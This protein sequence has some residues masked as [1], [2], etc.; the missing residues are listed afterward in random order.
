MS[1]QQPRSC[2]G[3]LIPIILISCGHIAYQ[4]NNY[5]T[6]FL[7]ENST[8]AD[9]TIHQLSLD[10]KIGQLFILT[11][12]IPHSFSK[13]QSIISKNHLGGI[14]LHDI[15][16]RNYIA[17]IQKIRTSANLP[18]LELTDAHTS[19]NNQLSD[20]VDYPSN[21]TLSA[22][23]WDYVSQSIERKYIND[24][25]AMGINCSLS[26][27]IQTFKYNED[28]DEGKYR[29]SNNLE[30]I[31]YAASKVVMLQERK[32]LAIASAMN[33]YVDS[34]ADSTLIRSGFLKEFKPLVRSG[35]SGIL[36]DNRL[37]EGD[38]I[39]NRLPEFYKFFLK[40]HLQFEGLL[41]GKIDEQVSIKELLYAG[42]DL[43][44]IP[45]EQLDDAKG[46][47]EAL[48]AEGIISEATIN[49]KVHK[50]LLAKKWLGL[51]KKRPTRYV[52]YASQSKEK[53]DELFV[54]HLFEQS[55][56]LAHNPDSLL[57]FKDTYAKQFKV[58]NIG[59]RSLRTFNN[60]FFKYANFSSHLYR[61]QEDGKVNGLAFNPIKN[62][63]F[64]LT[65][66][67]INLSPV[68]HAQFIQSVNILSKDSKVVV[69]NFGNP[70]NFN[71]FDS[72][73]VAIQVFEKNQITEELVPQLLFG[74]IST[75]GKLPIEVSS[76]MPKG[77][78]NQIP[79]NRLKFTIPEEVGIPS[80]KLTKIDDIF[81]EAILRKA[82]PG[83]QVLVA[84]SGK[85]IYAKTFGHHTYEQKQM[86]EYT[87]LYDVASITKVAATTLAAM[88]LY[89]NG[90]I[91]VNTTLRNEIPLSSDATIKNIKIKDLFIHKSGLQRNMPIATYLKNRLMGDA[92][93][94]F[95]CKQQDETYTTEI[96]KDLYMN[97]TYQDSIMKE[98]NLLPRK[99]RHRRYLY[100]DVNFFLI[101]QLI[102]EK[103]R[104][105]LDDYLKWK[106]YQPLG[107][108]YCTFKPLERFPADLI[109]PTQD[110]Q[111][112]RK[113][114]VRGYVHDE[115]AALLGG[116]GGNAGLFA[117]AADLAALF[118]M[119]LNGGNYGG[120][121][122]LNKKTIDYFTSSK[123][124]N[125]RGL[126]FDKA[127]YNY[128]ASRSASIET[129]G[130]SGFSGT[131]VWVDPEEELIY[132]FL[133]NRIHPDARNPRLK[134]MRIRQRIHQV[135]YD[136][137]QSIDQP[138]ATLSWA[139]Q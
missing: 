57:P 36:I 10:E 33:V 102:E 119:L 127:R 39:T 43:F 121:K 134:K 79:T 107:L 114:L 49:E 63:A 6:P 78:N 85:V 99:Y 19:F 42:T 56:I 90:A 1:N 50:I 3:F 122:F 104:M 100:S 69:V 72:T 8:W 93:N 130:H 68:Q 11:S 27:D 24:L 112:W 41:F 60:T 46:Q 77:A 38:T 9:T 48:I 66:D 62:G 118:Q 2:L 117:N 15:S 7:Q 23:D 26:P 115:S 126:G 96:A 89:E 110:D 94:A 103:T 123:H 44:L 64:I 80:E 109:V 55:I 128:T 113:G 76:W 92:C 91:D 131:C 88:T 12:D 87:D 51:E 25:D 58:V 45:E 13:T 31:E 135:I 29:I 21:A 70:N 4:Q 65:L 35:L 67:N 132:I 17:T 74:G 40:R 95:F 98:V 138:T 136:A 14:L 124:G 84:K 83:G 71:Q 53:E 73:I 54:R 137:I 28:Y 108:R 106:Y 30:E 37:F 18:L 125:H 32:I 86:V 82:T 101:H 47:L 20:M 52:K 111:Y 133:S 34:I 129:Y 105:D 97:A 81:Q 5:F 116:V 139:G 16:K 61:P 59:K 75:T 120:Q 22:L